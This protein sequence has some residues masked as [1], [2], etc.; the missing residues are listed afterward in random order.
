M[1]SPEIDQVAQKLQAEKENFVKVQTQ[2]IYW[3]SFVDET[4]ISKN[5]KKRIILN[6]MTPSITTFH[7][8]NIFEY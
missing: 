1:Y 4:A 8:F 5:S 7:E 3:S 6:M 2:N